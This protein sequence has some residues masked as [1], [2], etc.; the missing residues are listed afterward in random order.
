MQKF[1]KDGCQ[2]TQFLMLGKDVLEKFKQT[3]G[4]I[5]QS[6]PI[7]QSCDKWS[8]FELSSHVFEK[9]SIPDPVLK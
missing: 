4:Q 6:N 1:F 2:F 9:W 7:F 3:Q 8:N 5:S